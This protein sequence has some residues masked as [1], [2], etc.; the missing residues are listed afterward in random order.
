MHPGKAAIEAAEYALAGEVK[1]TS[2]DGYAIGTFAG[3]CF[4]CVCVEGD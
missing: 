2:K 3:G 4:W 1:S